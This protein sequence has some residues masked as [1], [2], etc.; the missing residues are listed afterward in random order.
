MY[1]L[2]HT[3]I[4]MHMHTCT[5]IGYV[6]AHTLMHTL[7]YMCTHIH[8]HTCTHKH[9]QKM[10]AQEDCRNQPPEHGRMTTLRNPQELWSPA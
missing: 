2:M 9:T 8:S 4:R 10:R 3:H 6:Y 7:T 5:H 1:S